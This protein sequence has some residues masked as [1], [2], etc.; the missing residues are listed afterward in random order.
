MSRRPYIDQSI[1]RDDLH[2]ITTYKDGYAQHCPK[3]EPV[4]M[5]GRNDWFRWHCRECDK[6]FISL[7]SEKRM[8]YYDCTECGAS[9]FVYKGF[10][11]QP[12][13]N[14]GSETVPLKP[15]ECN[16][17]LLRFTAQYKD[18]GRTNEFYG[19]PSYLRDKAEG[20][21]WTVT[22]AYRV[23]RDGTENILREGEAELLSEW[24]NRVEA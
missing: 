24:E 17:P 23:N 19:G 7:R 16:E 22:A 2:A 9:H 4:G 8:K 15:G 20:D 1:I 14:N 6:K 3:Y 10:F 5:D 12:D 13:K 21:Y 11:S 18:S